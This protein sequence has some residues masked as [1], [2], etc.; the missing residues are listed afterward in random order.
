MCH[1]HTGGI[2]W[3]HADTRREVEELS[4]VVSVLSF[5]PDSWLEEPTEQQQREARA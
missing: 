1:D 4:L 5:D 2:D 3:N